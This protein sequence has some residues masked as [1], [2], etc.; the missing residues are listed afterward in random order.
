MELDGVNMVIFLV[1]VNTLGTFSSLM[2]YSFGV[3]FFPL[4]IFLF[5]LKDTH[6]SHHSDT[7]ESIKSQRDMLFWFCKSGWFLGPVLPTPH[8]AW[9]LSLV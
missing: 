1:N 5:I 4:S 7:G 3:N 8:P 6:F 2:V 9:T